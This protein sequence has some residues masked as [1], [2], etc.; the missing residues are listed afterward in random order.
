[1]KHLIVS[2]FILIIPLQMNYGQTTKTNHILIIDKT[3][4]M[5]GK[6]TGS[7]NE[8]IWEEVKTAIKKYIDVIEI[9][10]RISI[11]FFA[12]KIEGPSVFNINE[13]SDLD[14]AKQFVDNIEADGQYTCTYNSLNSVIDNF[15][16]QN[17]GYKNWIFLYT[18]GNNT[19]S[20]YTMEQ[21]ADAFNAKRDDDDYIYYISLGNPVPEEVERAATS[22]E[23]ILVQWIP[24]PGK[25]IE[26]PPIIKPKPRKIIV[27]IK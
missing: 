7:G 13:Q 16:Q 20:G 19:C 11:Y 27:K 2:F 15:K 6:P 3:G 1:M 9:E 4:S 25:V 10:D 26:P 22:N 8:D 14:E 5:V 21:V 24:E 23:G 12:E 18:D 17:Q